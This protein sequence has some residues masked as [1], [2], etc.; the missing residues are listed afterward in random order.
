M[1][2]THYILNH[3]K[4]EEVEYLFVL[5]DQFLIG[6]ALL[7]FIVIE[8]FILRE[9]RDNHMELD[10]FFIFNFFNL[11]ATSAITLL[12]MII[13]IHYASFFSYLAIILAVIGLKIGL[14]YSVKK[15]NKEV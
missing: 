12:T 8:I 1:N 11:L 6:L 13:M 7:V 10:A 5:S 4:F 15:K 2:L 14:Y 9:V 3:S